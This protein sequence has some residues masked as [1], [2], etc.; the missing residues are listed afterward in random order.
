M[1]EYIKDCSKP[2]SFWFKGFEDKSTHSFFIGRLLKNLE[3]HRFLLELIVDQLHFLMDHIIL[4]FNIG[5]RR[6]FLLLKSIMEDHQDLAKH[7]ERG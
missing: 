3:N 7:I 4:K 5:R 6:D 1:L 2:E